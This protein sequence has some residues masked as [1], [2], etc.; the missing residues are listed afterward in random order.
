MF[1]H[2]KAQDVP[3][4]LN[5]Q[6]SDDS[7]RTPERKQVSD[8]QG[9]IAD[10]SCSIEE[11]RKSEINRSLIR[12]SRPRRQEYDNYKANFSDYRPIYQNLI[13]EEPLSIRNS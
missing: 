8:V 5:H 7:T 1:S 13:R 12:S 11:E 4:R 9:Y 6:S 10:Q 3:M 2:V